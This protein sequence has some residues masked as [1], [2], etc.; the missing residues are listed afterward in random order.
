MDVQ[1]PA[2]AAAHALCTR[3][4]LFLLHCLYGNAC[5]AWRVSIQLIHGTQLVDHQTPSRPERLWQ[6]CLGTWAP[7]PNVYNEVHESNLATMQ[8]SLRQSPITGC[9]SLSHY[10]NASLWSVMGVSNVSVSCPQC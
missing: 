5:S 2:C 3:T 7:H 9:C 8:W 4:L 10:G 1:A 6:W